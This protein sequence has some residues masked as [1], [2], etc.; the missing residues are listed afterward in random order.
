MYIITD[1]YHVNCPAMQQNG[2]IFWVGEAI[3]QGNIKELEARG[4]GCSETSPRNKHFM[5]VETV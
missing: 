4:R 3:N 5:N 2:S 1:T